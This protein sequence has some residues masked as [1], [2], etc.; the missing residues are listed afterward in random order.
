MGQSLNQSNQYHAINPLTD[1]TSSENNAPNNNQ[2][3]FKEQT[4]EFLSNLED[5]LIKQNQNFLGSIK[6]TLTDVIRQENQNLANA[7]HQENQNLANAIHQENQTLANAIRQENQNLVNNLGY[8]IRKQ[9]QAHNEEIKK[10][11]KNEIKEQLKSSNSITEESKEISEKSYLTFTFAPKPK[12]PMDNKNAKNKKIKKKVNK[13]LKND[14]FLE[15]DSKINRGDA[16]LNSKEDLKIMGDE[17]N[18]TIRNKLTSDIND[19]N[20]IKNNDTFMEIK[21]DISSGLGNKCTFVFKKKII[22]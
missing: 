18:N 11:I 10:I 20:Y 15:Y 9:N 4:K 1:A 8:I 3:S 14:F 5:I 6:T 21:S 2:Q 17:F 7:I 13:N 22:K 19:S 12:E 16:S